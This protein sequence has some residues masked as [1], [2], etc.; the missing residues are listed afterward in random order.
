MRL[1]AYASRSLDEH[2]LLVAD[3]PHKLVVVA[4]YAVAVH[5][6]SVAAAG[7]IAAVRTTAVVVFVG[8]HIAV[9]E[10]DIAGCTE[11]VVVVGKMDLPIGCMLVVVD[12]E[13][14]PAPA[15]GQC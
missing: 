1:T 3:I 15:E 6:N 2:S 5:H 12:L 13:N 14:N 9:L 4:R 7:D 8:S 10:I 11:V